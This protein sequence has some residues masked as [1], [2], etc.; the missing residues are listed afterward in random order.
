M[1][2]KI[3]L[4]DKEWVIYSAQEHFVP[5]ELLLTIPG[6]VVTKWK[7]YDKPAEAFPFNAATKSDL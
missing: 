3:L 4:I 1:F 2:L 6:H 5:R 7:I